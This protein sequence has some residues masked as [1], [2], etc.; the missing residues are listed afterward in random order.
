M[1]GPKEY[2]EE[3]GN[4]L[5]SQGLRVRLVEGEPPLLHVENPKSPAFKEVIG[6]R[7]GPDRAEWF[8]WAAL[9]VLLAPVDQVSTAVERVALV[10]DIPGG[11]ADG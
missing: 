7:T 8:H 4:S 10:L 1:A 5:A 6:C 2:L 11:A 9:D 3:L